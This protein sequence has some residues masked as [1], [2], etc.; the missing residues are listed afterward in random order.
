MVT[1][2]KCQEFYNEIQAVCL[3]YRERGGDIAETVSHDLLLVVAS[4]VSGAV[5]RS[6]LDSAIAYVLSTTHEFM[7]RS[8]RT[9][10]HKQH[11]KGTTH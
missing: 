4:M 10:V 1:K 9:W 3:R 8:Y 7:D 11:A 2:P 6:G 5:S